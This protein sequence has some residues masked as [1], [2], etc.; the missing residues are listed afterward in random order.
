MFGATLVAIAS[1]LRKGH[2]LL[3]QPIPQYSRHGSIGTAASRPFRSLG[4]SIQCISGNSKCGVLGQRV[5]VAHE[6]LGGKA[7]WSSDSQLED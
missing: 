5:T 7:N 2:I 3:G 1:E 6:I 4:Y